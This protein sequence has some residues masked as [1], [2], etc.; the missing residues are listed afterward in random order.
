MR[1]YS[2][3]RKLLA[4]GAGGGGGGGGSGPGGWTCG[5]PPPPPPPQPSS[6]TA[7]ATVPSADLNLIAGP[8]RNGRVAAP[9]ERERSSA[10]PAPLRQNARHVIRAGA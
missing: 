10:V 1:L 5:M 9:A 6:V 7:I 2:V 4:V 3:V 8:K